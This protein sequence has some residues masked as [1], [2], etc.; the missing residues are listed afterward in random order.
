MSRT[1]TTGVLK[2]RN[3]KSRNEKSL[4][5]KTRYNLNRWIEDK[6]GPSIQEGYMEKDHPF[7][8]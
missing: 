1:L 8:D 2:S 6:I 7:A 4:Y 3:V 5:A